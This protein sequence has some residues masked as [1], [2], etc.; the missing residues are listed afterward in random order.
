MKV[1]TMICIRGRARRRGGIKAGE[2]LVGGAWL[3]ERKP[4]VPSPAAPKDIE[5]HADRPEFKVRPAQ[6][7]QRLGPAAE[8]ICPKRAWLPEFHL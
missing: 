1:L 6:T 8:L 5:P 7:K 3:G 4:A 2:S